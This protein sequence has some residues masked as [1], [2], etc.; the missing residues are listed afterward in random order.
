VSGAPPTVQVSTRA[1]VVLLLAATANI[2]PAMN[3]SIMNVIYRDI[4]EEFPDVSPAQLSWV[5]SAYT[6]VSA[7]TLVIGGVAADRLGRKRA[8]LGGCAGFALG[9]LLCGSANNVGMIISG[10]IVMG[11]A[12]SFVI[13]S[14]VSL[15]LREFPATR[16]STAFG[17]I[18]SFGGLAAAAGPT[19]GSVVLDNGGWRWAFLVNVPVALTIVVVGLRVF[20]ESRDPDARAFPDVAGA[21]L[22][23]VGVALGIVAVVQS[24][25]WGWL[26][27]R[28]AAC[29]VASAVTIGWMLRRCLRHPEPIIDLRLF[30]SRNLSVFN[31]TAFLVSIGWFGM[32]FTMV[33]FLRTTW[34]YDVLEAGLLVTPIPFGAGV[35]G[36]LG[37]RVGDRFGYRMMMIVGSVAFVVGSIWMILALGSEPDVA[38]WMVGIGFIALGTGLVFPSFQAGAV[39]D[40][41]L[42]QYAVAVGVNQ[43]IQRVGAAVG[44]AV[45]IAFLASVGPAGA[46]DR[47]YVVMAL[48]AAACVPAALLL[49]PVTRTPATST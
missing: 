6:V 8:L 26:D 31:A 39:I 7:A 43:T 38:A 14:N 11:I 40:M 24:P 10:R 20:T 9:S 16:R 21:G 22:L 18:A 5:L 37:G 49:A 28:T 48:A 44:G 27:V 42:D 41:P 3:L 17:V 32:F 47:I 29:L 13:T 12:A 4:Q 19:V 35:L 34:E 2:L 45:A 1:W 30:R 25:T 23:L 33:Q 36:V 15:A 46:L